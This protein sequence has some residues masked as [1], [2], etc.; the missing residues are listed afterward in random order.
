MKKI[1]LRKNYLSYIFLAMLIVF[2][3]FTS[4]ALSQHI[5]FGNP[6]FDESYAQLDY[7]TVVKCLKN[8]LAK[9]PDDVDTILHLARLY[10]ITKSRG[11][12]DTA[13]EN[14]FEILKQKAEK[15]KITI[16]EKIE[17]A[18]LLMY[19]K[20]I[21]ESEKLRNEIFEEVEKALYVDGKSFDTD[22]MV[23]I[24]GLYRHKNNNDKS[25]QILDRIIKKVESGKDER[26]NW[27]LANLISIKA[28]VHFNNMKTPD[29]A[30]T[31]LKLLE[32]A[33]TKNPDDYVI[34]N[35]LAFYLK[36]KKDFDKSIKLYKE[37]TKQIKFD[38]YFNKPYVQLGDCFES[39]GM[40]EEAE[41][42]YIDDITAYPAHRR[43][44]TKLA[45]L[46]RNQGNQDK[47]ISVFEKGLK[48]AK[49][50]DDKNYVAY[51]KKMLKEEKALKS[52]KK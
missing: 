13:Y 32:E 16:K 2:S 20:K 24:S 48:A 27:I 30:M 37:L 36:K 34:K 11:E 42:A 5:S 38:K 8:R 4:E 18:G 10:R 52:E 44:Y 6:C 28:S 19:K 45:E 35:L 25:L 29:S 14:A 21:T 9:N 22:T 23:A 43:T 50:M 1:M 15:S 41:K 33:F 47:A 26:K 49:E 31:G 3:G 39:A 7:D 46:Y 51:F 17:Y 12:L 40:L